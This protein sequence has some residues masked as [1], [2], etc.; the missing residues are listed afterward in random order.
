MA[1]SSTL[2]S[3][4]HEEKT[5]DDFPLPTRRAIVNSGYPEWYKK[6]RGITGKA[7]LMPL[8][9]EFL[10]YLKADGIILPPDTP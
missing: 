7:R 3:Y 2:P 4:A 10:D 9:T 6:Y 1:T 5:I 8:T